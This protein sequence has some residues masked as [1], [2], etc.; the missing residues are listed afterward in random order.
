MAFHSFFI[1]ISHELS[2]FVSFFNC[3][4]MKKKSN[5][6]NQT[7]APGVEINRVVGVV[8]RSFEKKY[9]KFF[10]S[11]LNWVCESKLNNSVFSVFS[12]YYS[13]CVYGDILKFRKIYDTFVGNSLDG[14]YGVWCV[15][16]LDRLNKRFKQLFI[17]H[18]EL[19][20]ED[21]YIIHFVVV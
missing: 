18:T 3:L 13:H 8:G 11:Y 1:L 17:K 12:L 14:T 5:A 21:N 7:N 15:I 4:K 20:F 2:P 9:S 6:A 19:R 16:Y 10:F